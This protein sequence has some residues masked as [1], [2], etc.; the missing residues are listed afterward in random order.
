MVKGE[1]SGSGRL[2]E[3][4]CIWSSKDWAGKKIKTVSSLQ[5][6]TAGSSLLF[7]KRGRA[8]AGLSGSDER[9]PRESPPANNNCM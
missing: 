3:G 6:R 4:C 7:H 8:D 5:L 1:K 2:K 9:I